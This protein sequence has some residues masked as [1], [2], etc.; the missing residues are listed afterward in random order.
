M[1]IGFISNGVSDSSAKFILD[2]GKTVPII[3]RPEAEFVHWVAFENGEMLNKYLDGFKILHAS[4]LCLCHKKLLSMVRRP[5]VNGKLIHK[6][7]IVDMTLDEFIKLKKI[8]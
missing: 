5:R 6:L 1:E 8:S 2:S 4:F 3:K 7:C